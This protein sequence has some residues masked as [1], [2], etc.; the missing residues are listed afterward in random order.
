M[1]KAS[2]ILATYNMGEH[3]KKALTTILSQTEKNFELIIIDDSSTDDTK[4]IIAQ[5]KDPRIIYIHN[6]RNLGKSLTRNK[7]IKLAKSNYLFFT[8]ADCK[9]DKDWLKE[10]LQA[11]K[12]NDCVGV[13]GKIY[14]VSKNY[15]PTYSDRVVQNLSGGQ[16]M[17]ANM[18]YKKD[19]VIKAKLFDKRFKRNQDRD[20]ALKVKKIG[21][22]LFNKK[23]IVTHTISLWDPFAYFSSADWIYYQVVLLYK[24]HH[25]RH[26]IQFRIYEPKKLFAIFF[27]FVILLKLFI[28]GYKSKNDYILFLLC[29]PRI[30]YERLLLWKY[31]FKEKVFII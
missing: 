5:I 22:I 19:A 7:G 13:E 20:L 6:T 3:I 31:C 27:P 8:D 9:V 4:E 17:T 23:M 12:D 15:Q 14:Y 10:G 30:I 11:F 2:I 28:D 29:Y 18:A 16:Y 25:E 26:N 1:P 21:K 24:I